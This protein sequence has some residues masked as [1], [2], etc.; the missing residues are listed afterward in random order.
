[1]MCKMTVV[2]NGTKQFENEVERCEEKGSK[3]LSSVLRIFVQ[4][5][6]HR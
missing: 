4:E 3:A 6:Y 1:M 2:A 5:T